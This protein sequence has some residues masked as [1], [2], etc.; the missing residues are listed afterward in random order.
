M[1]SEIGE[2]QPNC[3]EAVFRFYSEDPKIIREIL[4]GFADEVAL[5]TGEEVQQIPVFNR[6]YAMS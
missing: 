6:A 1:K 3:S 4:Q 5:T 2:I